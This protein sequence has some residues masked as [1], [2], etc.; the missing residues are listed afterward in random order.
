[1]LQPYYMTIYIYT[2]TLHLIKR[3][4]TRI[5]H[6]YPCMPPAPRLTPDSGSFATK[7]SVCPVLRVVLQ[8]IHMPSD[9]GLGRPVDGAVEGLA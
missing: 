7:T 8:D 1:M 6:A 3:L 5:P 4:K 9:A 2:H